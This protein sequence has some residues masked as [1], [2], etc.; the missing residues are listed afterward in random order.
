MR[1]SVLMAVIVGAT[2]PTE[3][4]AGPYDG[5]APHRYCNDLDSIGATRIPPLTS[6]QLELVE[7]LEQ[8]QIIAR[9]GA[10]APYGMIFCWDAHKHN[11][12]NAEWNCTPTSLSVREGADQINL[13]FGLAASSRLCT[14]C[15]S[16]RMSVQRKSREAS[17]DACTT[18]HPWMVT[19]SSTGTALLAVCFS[20]DVSSTRRT[21]SA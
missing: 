20:W 21:D 14:E 18:S 2:A 15:Y 16:S 4:T 5:W 8:V 3:V 9:H 11:P 7:S 10:R 19:I 6:E 1:L 13:H 12:M 17:S